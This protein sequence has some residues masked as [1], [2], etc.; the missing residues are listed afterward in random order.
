[1]S[2]TTLPETMKAI[3]YAPGETVPTIRSIRLPTQRPTHLIVKITDVALNPTDWKHVARIQGAKPFSIVGCDYA[4]TVVSIGPE[5]T[6]SF[7]VGDKVFG[8]GHGSNQ[9]ESNDGVFAEYA[10]VKADITMHVP[11]NS[12]L[13]I[14]DLSSIPLGTITVGQALFQKGKG[15]GLLFMPGED[16]GRGEWLLIYGGSTATGT[17]AI[18]FAKMAGYKVVTTC[19]PRNNDLVL[20]RG[21][22]KVFDYN[23]PGVGAKIRKFTAN[24]L[25]YAFDTVGVDSSAVICCEALSSDVKGLTLATVMNEKLPREDVES[26]FV[27]MYTVFGEYFDKMGYP[28]PASK[29]DHD[30]GKT[31]FALTEKLIAEG[32]LKSHPVKVGTGLEGVVQGMDDMKNEKV[33]G[34][35]LVYKL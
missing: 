15:L 14:E 32:K 16:K 5:V 20:S 9:S 6:K 35:K 26:K 21:A 1:M 31:W 17:L 25:R 19:S 2:S 27:L 23:E 7:K 24:T 22:D 29:E 12:P 28:F 3:T 33:R 4:G 30:F 34:E 18:Q 8:V 13:S 10:S 11:A